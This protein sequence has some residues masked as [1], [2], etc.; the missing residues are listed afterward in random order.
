MERISKSRI[1]F[2]ALIVL[3]MALF[4]QASAQFTR[5]DA[6]KLDMST[7]PADTQKGYK[8]FSTK[9]SECHD[10][11][12]SLTESRPAEYWREVVGRMAAMPSSH[13][14]GNEADLITKFLV[15]DQSHRR[16]HAD[17]GAAPHAAGP[18]S[19][20]KLFDGLGCSA[21]HSVSGQGNSSFPLDGIGS[22]LTPTE[23]RRKMTAP[24]KDSAMPAVPSDT[25]AA[26]LNEIANF[27]SGLKR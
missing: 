9:C 19:G 22:S 8:L 27:L 13:I 4:N 16:E 25:P 2:A 20:A 3:G 5:R 18:A 14:N 17:A 24:G 11:A 23:L 12:S 6:I 1:V 21:C 26:Q 15:Y 10:V 7:Y